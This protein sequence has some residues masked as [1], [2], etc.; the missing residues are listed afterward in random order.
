MIQQSKRHGW[1]N[2]AISQSLILGLIDAGLEV[3]V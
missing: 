2:L 3:R 1:L